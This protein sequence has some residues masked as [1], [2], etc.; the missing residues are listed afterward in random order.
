VPNA[1]ALGVGVTDDAM[2]SSIQQEHH[3]FDHVLVG[4]ER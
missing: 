3:R 1:T 2:A 4:E